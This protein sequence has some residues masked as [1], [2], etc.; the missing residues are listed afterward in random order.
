VENGAKVSVVDGND[1]GIAGHEV[2]ALSFAGSPPSFNVSIWKTCFLLNGKIHTCF[3]WF[4]KRNAIGGFAY[5]CLLK[6]MIRLKEVWA[7]K[8][9]MLRA[10]LTPDP[11]D[12]FH[13]KFVGIF[14]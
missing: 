2:L 9:L 13:D 12:N 7:V 6:I 1:I 11:I 10:F 14:F 8:Q 4:F 3:F 5:K